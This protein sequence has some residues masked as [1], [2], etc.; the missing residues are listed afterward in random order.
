MS[1]NSVDWITQNILEL[2][3]LNFI[4]NTCRPIM[5]ISMVINF[6]PLRRIV[7]I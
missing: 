4:G 6:S 3:P 1:S 2:K 5:S 7:K